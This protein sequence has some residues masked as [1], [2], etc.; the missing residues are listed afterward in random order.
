MNEKRGVNDPMGYTMAEKILMRN[1]QGFP[2]MKPGQLE[3]Y[4]P[5][6]F[7]VHDIYTPLL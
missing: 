5:D 1:M 4:R 3:D 2:I 7:M 6:R